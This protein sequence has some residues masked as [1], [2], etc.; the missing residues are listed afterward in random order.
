MNK[1]MYTVQ[2]GQYSEYTFPTS[3][4]LFLSLLRRVYGSLFLCFYFP[5]MYICLIFS[6]ITVSD[7][8]PFVTQT[9]LRT[10]FVIFAL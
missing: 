8:K 3:D 4:D 5:Y 9:G 10:A 7:L 1:Y 6:S 2:R